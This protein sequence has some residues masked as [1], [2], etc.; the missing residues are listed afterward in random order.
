MI[1]EGLLDED[2]SSEHLAERRCVA[3][4]QGDNTGDVEDF[5]G[6]RRIFRRNM[7]VCCPVVHFLPAFAGRACF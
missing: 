1:T 6:K 4:L 5:G 2:L 7:M 3:K